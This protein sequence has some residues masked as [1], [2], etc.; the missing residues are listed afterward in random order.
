ML[1]AR[2]PQK[3]RQVSR[4]GFGT[5]MKFVNPGVKENFAHNDVNGMQRF[6]ERHPAKSSDNVVTLWALAFKSQKLSKSPPGQHLC[7]SGFG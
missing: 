1:V 7:I 3:H 5:Q 2:R 6:F 4:F